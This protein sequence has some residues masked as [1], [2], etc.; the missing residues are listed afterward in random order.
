M[1]RFVDLK[2]QYH[3][4]KAEIDRAVT[5]VM[6]STSFIL[7]ENVE[8][9]EAEFADFV[10]A[11]HAIG[12]NSG[13]DALALALTAVGVEPG[14]E[15]IVPVNT[16]IA[17][18]LAVS[19]CG[20]IPRFVDVRAGT[21]NIDPEKAAAAVNG[22]TRAIVPVHLYGQPAEMPAIMALAEE[23][24]LQVVEDACQA[25]GAEYDGRGV[26]T[27]GNAACYSFYPGKNLGA[28]GDGGMVVTDGDGLAESLR[29]A[30]H[31]GQRPKNHH[32]VKGQNTRLDEMQAAILRVKLPHLAEW[33]ARRAEVADMYRESLE[34]LPIGLPVT[35]PSVTRHVWHLFVI[36][37]DE[38]EA[39][40]AFLDE[41]G[42]QTGRHY[43]TPIHI[44]PAYA[45]LGGKAG[46]F[47]VAE[48]MA[49]RLLSLPMHPEMTRALV[50]EVVHGVEDFFAHG[51]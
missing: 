10:G 35:H 15:V 32:R 16:F 34:H 8:Q 2:T 24:G 36:Q 31:F 29:L 50:D 39:L 28:Y 21:A 17:T 33:N 40:G 14:D 4:L 6:E 9:F 20:A 11:R 1:I 7:G 48:A 19:V 46:D 25:H 43:P 42:I 41:R 51:G 3:G 26:G 47:P 49:S 45:E 18:A 37:V 12:V 22:N 5:A 13:T 30:R 38:P 23:K 27:F 44:Q